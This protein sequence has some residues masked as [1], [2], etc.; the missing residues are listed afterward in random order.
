MDNKTETNK[1]MEAIE[2]RA[3]Y[4]ASKAWMKVVEAVFCAPTRMCDN[5]HFTGQSDVLIRK[6]LE[7]SKESFVEK[8][9]SNR[10]AEFLSKWQA[11][12]QLLEYRED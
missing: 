8:F 2:K 7:N 9:V 6:A 11:A 4:D 3:K 5:F 12:A 10:V 1:L